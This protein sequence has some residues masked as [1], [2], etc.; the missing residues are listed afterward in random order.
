M[1]RTD[2][3]SSMIDSRMIFINGEINRDTAITVIGN[4]LYLDSLNS[5]DI[6][7]YINSPGGTVSD[8]LAIIDTME[9]LKSKVTVIGYGTVASMAA[10]ILACG[11][12]RCC[13]K[14]TRLM[15]HQMYGGIQ[16]NVSDVE[17][18]YNNM[19][20]IKSDIMGLLASK[21]RKTIRQVE[22]DCERDHW[23]S[24]KEAK[25]YGLIDEVL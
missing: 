1:V 20:E 14:H 18:A 21:V 6:N 16:G 2:L 9:L 4:L 22:K 13:L 17:I 24:A 25:K 7:I 3:Q 10:V 5:E 8:G 11:N 15:I 23:M 19:M 12:R